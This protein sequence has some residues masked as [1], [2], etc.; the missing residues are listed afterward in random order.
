MQWHFVSHLD[1]VG[2]LR[3]RMAVSNIQRVQHVSGWFLRDDGRNGQ[4]S[5]RTGVSHVVG[6]HYLPHC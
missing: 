1:F 6:L 3:G 2:Q 5:E 4:L